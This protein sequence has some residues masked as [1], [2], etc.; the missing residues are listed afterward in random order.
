M[1]TLKKGIKF[2]GFGIHSGKKVEL[3]VEPSNKPGIEFIYNDQTIDVSLN[4]LG[5]N[6]LRSTTLSNQ[7]VTIQT[8]EHFL[9]A[10]YALQITNISVTLTHYEF[11]ILDGSALQ[12]VNDFKNNRVSLKIESLEKVII[13]N[14]LSFN[15][16]GSSY[17][18]FPDSGFSITAILSYPNDWIKTMSYSYVHSDSS[19]IKEI[20]PARTYGFEREIKQLKEQGLAKGGSLDNAL[21]ISKDGYINQPRFN[22]ELVRHKILD[23]IGDIAILG[24]RFE[25]HFLIIKPSHHCNCEFIKSL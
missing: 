1:Y 6:H 12:Y 5:V 22:N 11:P 8:P 16:N 17:Y 9:A 19:F 13:E 20:A 2:E 14:E 18:A 7:N 15:L 10:C 21:V 23:F 3:Y 4:S 25:G 24:K